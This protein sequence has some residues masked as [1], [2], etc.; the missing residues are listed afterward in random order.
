MTTKGLFRRF[1]ISSAVMFFAVSFSPL[2]AQVKIGGNGNSDPAPGTILDLSD[3]KFGGLLLPQVKL[4]DAKALPTDVEGTAV[5]PGVT[6]SND[7]A[8]GLKVGT[9][10]YNIGTASLVAG[11]YIWTGTTKGWQPVNSSEG[12]SSGGSYTLPPA[13]T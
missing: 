12:G 7:P 4:T 8:T 6:A 11:I 5:W 9:V 13:T 1:Q 3:G 10:V 2:Q